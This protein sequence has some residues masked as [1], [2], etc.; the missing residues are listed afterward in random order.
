MTY[1]MQRGI[2]ILTQIAPPDPSINSRLQNTPTA[3]GIWPWNLMTDSLW[4]ADIEREWHQEAMSVKVFILQ[5]FEVDLEYQIPIFLVTATVTG[6]S[7]SP[8]SL[9][10]WECQLNVTNIMLLLNNSSSNNNNTST[11]YN[12]TGEKLQTKYILSRIM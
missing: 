7:Q 10:E 8:V 1:K 12:E 9:R 5:Q 4:H 6:L 3:V 11:R 2:Y